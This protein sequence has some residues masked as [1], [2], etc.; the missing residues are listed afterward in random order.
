MSTEKMW[1][2]ERDIVGVKLIAGEE[3]EAA[4]AV[5]SESYPDAVIE[6]YPAYLS[7][8]APK[9]VVF[10]LRQISERLGRPYDAPTFLVI[11]S[12]YHGRINVDDDRITLSSEI[13]RPE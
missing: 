2:E 12:S 13:V 1:I 9:E 10:D 8:E 4:A 7:I 11:M 3:A 5:I 6:R